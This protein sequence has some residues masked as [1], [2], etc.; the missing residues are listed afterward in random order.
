M[1]LK[2]KHSR[3]AHIGS[4][5]PQLQHQD[6]STAR[7]PVAD[8]RGAGCASLRLSPVPADARGRPRGVARRRA[9]RRS[10]G[11]SRS[12]PA[13]RA[14]ASRE[15]VGAGA[16][17][18]GEVAA[19]ESADAGMPC[20]RRVGAGC[21]ALAA[22][23]PAPVRVEALVDPAR[24]DGAEVG[25]VPYGSLVRVRRSG[26][27]PW[28]RSRDEGCCAGRAGSWS[29]W[30]A[31]TSRCWRSWPGTTSGCGSG[32]ASGRQS[33]WA[34]PT[35]P[36]SRPCRT[37]SPSGP[38]PAASRCPSSSWAAWS[39]TSRGAG[40]PCPRGSAGA[41]RHGA[42]SAEILLVPSPFVLGA[43]AGALVVLAARRRARRHGS[44]AAPGGSAAAGSSAA[45][46]ADPV[47]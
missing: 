10:S 20:G 22:G 18:A 28:H 13:R 46:G 38:G 29:G 26:G 27:E 41:S 45:A 40:R 32:R 44:S 9:R 12:S 43:V 36:R 4:W 35:G 15:E 3:Q 39:G 11:R 42:C 25:T 30:G 6:R 21:E 23:G 33:L 47:R 19:G 31:G 17:R 16:V 7:R 14:A 5:V 1:R 37:Q 24:R 34:R 8:H 2:E